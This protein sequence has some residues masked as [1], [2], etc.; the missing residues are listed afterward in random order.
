MCNSEDDRLTI[1]LARIGELEKIKSGDCTF[2]FDID[3]VIAKYN[4]KL[5]YDNSEPNENMIE[6]VNKLYDYGNEIILFTARGSKTGIDWSKITEEQ[7]K[8]FGVKYTELRM[9]KPAATYYVDDKSMSLEELY[10]IGG[11]L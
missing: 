2:V 6:I 10:L 3:G 7:M 5:D 1:S 9:G 8:R 11:E 4:P